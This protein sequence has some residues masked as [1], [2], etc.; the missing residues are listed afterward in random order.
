MEF[1]VYAPCPC[2]SGKKLKFCCAP[3]VE[4]MAKVAR[5]QAGDQPRQALAILEKLDKSHPNN[6]WVVTIQAEVLIGLQ[7][8]A[9]AKARLE[10]LLKD[11]TDYPPA[12]AMLALS[13]LYAEGYE[14]ARPA[15]HRALQKCIT[16]F[17]HNAAVLAVAIAAVLQESQCEM[18]ARQ[19]LS[20]SMR[21]FDK[22]AREE[23][24]VMLLKMDGDPEVPYPLRNVHQLTVYPSDGPHTADASK[25]NALATYG[26]WGPAARAYFRIAEQEPQNADLWQNV[27]LCRAWDA[28]EP[29]AAEAFHR[30]ASL[31]SDF[32]FAVENET[33]AQ[34]LDLKTS[35]DSVLL[36]QAHFPIRSASRLLGLLDGDDRFSRVPQPK[37]EEED[38]IEVAG[39]F[40]VKNKPLP[41]EA[42]LGQLSPEEYAFIAATLTVFDSNPQDGR[43]AAAY[44][45]GY[46]G[47]GFDS[48][49]QLVERLAGEEI[50]GP[51]QAGFDE[52][53]EA[54][55]REQLP[56]FRAWQ[57]PAQTPASVR[58]TL[59]ETRW[60]H[61]IDDVWFNSPQAALGD[62][63]PA[64]AN[65]DPASRVKLT[66]AAYVLDALVQRLRGRL[67][68]DELL[69][70]LNLDPPKTIEPTDVTLSALSPMQLHRL[71]VSRLTDAQLVY[72]QRRAT[73][74]GHRR[75][76]DAVLKELVAR[77]QCL[78]QVDAN[79]VFYNLVDIAQIDGRFDDAIVFAKQAKERASKSKDQGAFE[80]I[81]SWTV[82]EFA[83][84][85]E[86]P[87]DP[88]LPALYRLLSEYYAPKV[89]HVAM[90]LDVFRQQHGERLPWLRSAD[91]LVGSSTGGGSTPGGLWTPDSAPAPTPSGG[92]L[93]LPGQE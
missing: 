34:L 65:D 93:W 80:Q 51:V 83:L 60:R 88:E 56:F 74:V 16:R 33:L 8:P 91:L 44:L 72:T 48:S 62:K 77:P 18:S 73:L 59:I 13:T 35:S 87:D 64:A 41:T 78:E 2:G 32:E 89:P 21:L 90:I 57:L 5:L 81:L 27:A 28:D 24:F 20:L 67:D 38:E 82:T 31:S 6:P 36:R 14:A 39:E 63:S 17:P 1:D 92:K 3:I 45:R 23:V 76:V 58:H 25:A 47:E 4:D 68:F 7:E 15:I 66:A 26:C 40:V 22:E 55:P 11:H 50:A 46:A 12:F 75:F 9:Q 10:R 79:R 30:A 49:L 43:E 54:V 52:T 71:P 85:A 70:R 61:L 42:E 84:R 19:Y 69:R 86:Q 53:A 29:A 37:R